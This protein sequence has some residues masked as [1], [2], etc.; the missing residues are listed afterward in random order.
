M[1][2]A[3]A[4]GRCV[5]CS[6]WTKFPH[7]IASQLINFAEM[8]ISP[9]HNKI[10]PYLISP[11][12][13]PHKPVPKNFANHPDKMNKPSPRASLFFLFLSISRLSSVIIPRMNST[14]TPLYQAFP[15]AFTPKKKKKNVRL[16]ASSIS[17]QRE[18]PYY[19]GR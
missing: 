18:K 19:R 5:S 2:V 14:P 9:V 6:R 8:H 4:G 7:P 1:L 17:A 16:T 15:S 3:R 11:A 10:T 12:A 13:E